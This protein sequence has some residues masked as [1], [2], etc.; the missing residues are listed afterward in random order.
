MPPQDNSRASADKISITRKSYDG[1]SDGHRTWTVLV[2][3]N[4][5]SDVERILTDPFTDTTK[6]GEG[7][8]LCDEVQPQ[9]TCISLL[10]RI[11]GVV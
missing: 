10:W 9:D 11:L 6:S 7:I 3:I 2:A 8:L 5:E 1:R 4:G